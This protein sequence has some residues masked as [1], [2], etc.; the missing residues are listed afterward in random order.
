MAPTRANAAVRR[1]R[2]SRSGA[3]FASSARKVIRQAGID[4]LCALAGRDCQRGR[5]NVGGDDLCPLG[6][7]PGNQLAPDPAR[8][9]HGNAVPRERVRAE[10]RLRRGAKCNIGADRRRDGGGPGLVGA[11]GD[12]ARRLGHFGHVFGFRADV[13]TGKVSSAQT[14]H[15]APVGGQ[16]LGSLERLGVADDHGFRAADGNAGQR[17]LVGHRAGQPQDVV[18]CFGFVR[19]GS[20]ADAAAAPAGHGRWTA[21]M[22]RRPVF[23]SVTNVVRW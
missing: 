14:F 4:D 6:Q 1:C 17:H 18:Q 11:A 19:I 5:I 12:K 15:I 8:T 13:G 21:W 2:P 20:N 10:S 23:A 3:I 16:K 9:L 22:A 7:Q